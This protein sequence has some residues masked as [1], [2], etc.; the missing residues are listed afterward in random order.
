MND[1]RI[2][3]LDVSGK[4]VKSEMV[5]QS[6]VHSMDI[7]GLAAGVYLYRVSQGTEVISSDKLVIA[8]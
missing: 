8:E 4:V 1:V 3:M 6:S 5:N 7:A 2:E